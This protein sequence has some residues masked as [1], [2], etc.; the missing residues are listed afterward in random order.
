MNESAHRHRSHLMLEIIALVFICRALG[1]IVRD[2]GRTAI[3]YQVLAVALWFLFEFIGAIVVT[4]VI[5]VATGNQDPDM[6]Y[7]YVG[8]LAGAGLSLFISF[9]IVKM[10]PAKSDPY[11]H[12]PM[13]RN[14]M[15][16]VPM[17]RTSMDQ[18]S[19]SKV[20][21]GVRPTPAPVTRTRPQTPAE[22]TRSPEY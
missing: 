14:P 12:V 20:N 6:L 8:A 13:D 5:I 19:R 22:S 17:D 7:A 1:R 18:T 21:I 10:L 9:G 15:G 11:A 3:G 16:H 4:I 2:K